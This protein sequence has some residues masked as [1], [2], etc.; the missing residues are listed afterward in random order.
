MKESFGIWLENLVG[1][2]GYTEILFLMALESSLFPVP[3]ELVMIPAG[4]RAARGELDPLL[5]VLAGGAGSLIGASVPLSETCVIAAVT[6]LER[7]WS[8][9]SSLKRLLTSRRGARPGRNPGSRAEGIS[10]PIASS[11]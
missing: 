6:S 8:A 4:Y 9:N 7:I 10:S 11:R 1:H 5:A 2:L 3:S